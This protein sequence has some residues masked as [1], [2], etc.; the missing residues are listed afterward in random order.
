LEVKRKRLEGLA[1]HEGKRKVRLKATRGKPEK[2]NAGLIESSFLASYTIHY[3]GFAL[4]VER[5]N[6]QTGKRLR[7]RE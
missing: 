5:T 3:Q 2:E 1:R 4:H 6:R 7:K